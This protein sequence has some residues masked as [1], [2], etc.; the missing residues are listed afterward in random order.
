MVVWSNFH[1]ALPNSAFTVS[2]PILP[3]IASPFNT[4]SVTATWCIGTELN[5]AF[6]LL[7]RSENVQLRSE[8][9]PMTATNR[10]RKRLFGTV[11]EVGI[12]AHGRRRDRM[13]QVFRSL[14]AIPW[15]VIEGL[16]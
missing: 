6:G 9:R 8:M 10:I 7:L 16:V 5:G 1:A 13:E 15:E 4:S 2:F 3:M 11:P 14:Q 12:S